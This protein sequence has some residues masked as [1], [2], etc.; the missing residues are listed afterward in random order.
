MQQVQ[1]EMEQVLG[2]VVVEA[3]VGEAVAALLQLIR[4]DRFA[5]QD[6]Q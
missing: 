1:E 6:I 5:F 4:P 2:V 3:L